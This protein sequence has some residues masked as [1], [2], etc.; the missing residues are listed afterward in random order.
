[1]NGI[2]VLKA[3]LDQ[4]WMWLMALLVDMK[5]APTTFPTPQ[6]GNHPLWVLGHLVH[7]EASMVAEFIQGKQDPLAKWAPL[8]GGGSTPATDASKYPSM[9]VLLAEFEKVRA[10]TLRL[11]ETSTDADLDKPSKAP[12]HLKGLFG[13]VGQVLAMIGLHCTFHAGQVAD[14][15]RAAGR[16]P[17]LA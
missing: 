14:A 3:S 16:K 5:D 12:D 2:A 6:G 7:S 13:T 17:V 8:F 11:L 1:M 10:G 9:D 15:R 4:S